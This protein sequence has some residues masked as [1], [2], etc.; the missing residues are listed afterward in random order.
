MFKTVIMEVDR[1]TLYEIA[2]VIEPQFKVIF[3]VVDG[4]GEIDCNTGVEVTEIGLKQYTLSS[5]HPT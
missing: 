1:Y 4:L 3:L 5:A 2:L